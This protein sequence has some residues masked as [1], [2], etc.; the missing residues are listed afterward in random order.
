MKRVRSHLES[1]NGKIITALCHAAPKNSLIASTLSD[2]RNKAFL[3]EGRTITVGECR[4][5]INCRSQLDTSVADVNAVLDFA[6]FKYTNDTKME[7]YKR[8]AIKFIA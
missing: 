4:H 5:L 6:V 1:I 8:R 2:E 3:K 7:E